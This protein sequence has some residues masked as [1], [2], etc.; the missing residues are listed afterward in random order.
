MEHSCIGQL[1]SNMFSGDFG[2]SMW[3]E[4]TYIVTRVTALR[5]RYDKLVGFETGTACIV[6]TVSKSIFNEGANAP[7]YGQ[8]ITGQLWLCVSILAD[9]GYL[10]S[11]NLCNSTSNLQSNL[12]ICIVGHKGLRQFHANK[13]CFI[14]SIGE[15]GWENVALWNS[16]NVRLQI[17]IFA[18]DFRTKCM[19]LKNECTCHFRQLLLLFL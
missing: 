6:F 15:T 8:Y 9:Y 18:L 5:L 2:Y 17:T 1:R 4:S 3:C 14:G 19:E 10:Y 11:I 16:A 12:N 7:I 13:Q